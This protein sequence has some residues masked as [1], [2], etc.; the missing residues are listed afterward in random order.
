MGNILAAP[1]RQAPLLEGT[2]KNLFYPPERNEYTYFDRAK[3][4]PFKSGSTFVKAAWAADAAMLAYGRFGKSAMPP[5]EF[6]DIL[7]GPAGFDSVQRIGDWSKHG[8]Q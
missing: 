4:L 8:T 1:I 6:E 7:K 3:S 2:W 5:S